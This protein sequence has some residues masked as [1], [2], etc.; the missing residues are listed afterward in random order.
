MKNSNDLNENQ[1]VVFKLSNEYYA[2]N[3]SKVKTIE[4]TTEFTRVP[5][6]E[7]YIKGVINLRGEVIPVINLR[8]RFML[9]DNKD[10]KER[11]VIITNSDESDIGLLVDSSSEVITLHNDEIDNPPKLENQLSDDFIKGIGKKNNRLIMLI[12]LDKILGIN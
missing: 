4:K 5:N 6:T 7:K 9:D 8:K 12:D 11:R 3:I 2:I 10:I 1:Y